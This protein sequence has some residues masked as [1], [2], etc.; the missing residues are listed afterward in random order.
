MTDHAT[1]LLNVSISAEWRAYPCWVTRT[2]NPTPTDMPYS[3]MSIDYGVSEILLKKIDEWNEEFQQLWDPADPAS[4]E[5]PSK[6]D[7]E[8]WTEHGRQL[9][10]QLATE[11]GPDVR[12]TYYGE[13]IQAGSADRKRDDD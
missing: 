4:T 8:R 5:F 13:V 2:N 11:L 3:R 6:E 12:V 1:R 7:E 9:A 10:K